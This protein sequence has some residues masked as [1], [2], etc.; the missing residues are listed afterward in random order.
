MSKANVLASKRPA[1]AGQTRSDQ[2]GPPIWSSEANRLGWKGSGGNNKNLM[3]QTLRKIWKNFLA[4]L[5]LFVCLTGTLLT[6][7]V[8][9]NAADAPCPPNPT[10]PADIIRCTGNQSGLPSYETTSHANAAAQP[11]ANAITSAIFYAED[12][13]KYIMGAI[14]VMTIIISGVRLVTAGGKGI[15]EESKKQKDHLKYAIIGLVI[16]IVA[17]QFVQQVFFGQSGEIFGSESTLQEAATAGSE[18]IR[19]IYE[20]VAYISGALAILMIVIA[21]FRYLSS[22]GNE[23]KMKKAKDQII[24][25]AVGLMLIGIAEFAVKDVLFPQQGTQLPDV[26]KTKLLIINI[27]NFISGFMTTVAAVMYI[28]GGYIYVTAFGN[29]EA[30]GKAKKI[31][32]G[33]TVGLLLAMAAFAIVNTTVKLENQLGPATAAGGGNAA[34]AGLPTI[35][36]VGR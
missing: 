32:I 15:E 14:A 34:P 18:Q 2:T 12:F 11:G 13:A 25:A 4:P 31:I 7:V 27:T 6:L 23:E 35:G 3:K 1:M 28:Y 17:D 36:T 8:P 22:G 9:A 29:E 20:V 24:Y 26:E 21:G 16:I 33:A 5:A 19:G 30:T 10:T